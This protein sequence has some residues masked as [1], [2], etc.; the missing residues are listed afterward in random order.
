[1]AL[2]KD[3]LNS[4]EKN[5]LD[6]LLQSGHNKRKA[7]EQLFNTYSYLI[8]E[9]IRKHALSE[10]E[11]FDAYAD[12]VLSVISTVNNGT[13][14]G[15]SSLKTFVYQV[16]QN[17]CIDQVR[18]KSAIKNKVYQTFSITDMLLHLSDSAKSVI[19]SMIDKTD[20]DLLRRRLN[21]LGQNCSQLLLLSADGYTDKEIAMELE[22]KSADVAKT[23]RLRC[24]DKLRK[25]YAGI[26]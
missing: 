20:I 8:K 6:S 21:E 22:Y 11:S 4:T 10:D 13:F 5:I 15:R 18:K 17:K 19:Q 9:G 2:Q 3:L 24:L 7:E 12:A 1:M 26:Q 14:E 16:Y 23:S 25:L